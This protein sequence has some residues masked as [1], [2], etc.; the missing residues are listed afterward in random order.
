MA[1]GTQFKQNSRTDNTAPRQ[2]FGLFE[3][4][5]LVDTVRGLSQ[6]LEFSY[7]HDSP[8]DHMSLTGVLS[9]SAMQR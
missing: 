8:N 6:R 9:M 5:H 2:K 3:R 1:A 4:T 7:E